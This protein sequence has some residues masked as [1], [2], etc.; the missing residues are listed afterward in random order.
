MQLLDEPF[1]NLDADLKASI[2]TELREIL[3]RASITCLLVSHDQ[4]DV[5][6]ICDP[7]VALCQPMA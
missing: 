6:A 7:T 1:R 3:S 5:E 2:R 4:Q